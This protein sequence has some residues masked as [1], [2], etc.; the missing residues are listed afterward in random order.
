MSMDNGRQNMAIYKNDFS[1]QED[2]ALW[3]L[4]EIRQVVLL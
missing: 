1:L 2:Y 4:H 3:E